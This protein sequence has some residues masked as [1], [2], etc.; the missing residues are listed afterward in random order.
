[1]Q[2]QERAGFAT[3]LLCHEQATASAEKKGKL[4]RVS[5]VSARHRWQLTMDNNTIVASRGQRSAYRNLNYFGDSN[6]SQQDAEHAFPDSVSI[7]AQAGLD[8]F[9]ENS[10]PY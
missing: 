9:F 10:A 4:G 2:S 5:M 6:K 7:A 3:L 8:A 1:M